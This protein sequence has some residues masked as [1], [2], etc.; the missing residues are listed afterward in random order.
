MLLSDSADIICHHNFCVMSSI[1][2]SKHQQALVSSD[3]LLG[4]LFLSGVIAVTRGG[5]WGLELVRSGLLVSK[6][7]IKRG[8]PCFKT[9]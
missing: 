4:S 8:T 3:T 9:T 1:G 6:V 7:M 2:T 5:G